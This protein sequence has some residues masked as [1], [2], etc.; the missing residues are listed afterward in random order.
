LGDCPQNSHSGVGGRCLSPC[1]LLQYNTTLMRAPAWWAI[2]PAFLGPGWLAGCV[3][4]WAAARCSFGDGARCPP[5][6]APCSHHST[7]QR[8]PPPCVKGARG[9]R[10]C[11]LRCIL[12]SPCIVA[13]QG[14][15]ALVCPTLLLVDCVLPA[16]GMSLVR[17][18]ARLCCS[19]W[20]AWLCAHGHGTQAWRSAQP[21]FHRGVVW[22]PCM[23]R[24]CD[25]L[26]RAVVL[27]TEMR[28]EERVVWLLGWS[29]LLPCQRARSTGL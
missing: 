15:P 4:G 21:V 1:C 26:C 2:L 27:K 13:P 10:A 6:P 8:P 24:P 28:A 19:S 25:C 23:Y 22:C 3:A 12:S 17:R 16:R 29:W 20:S 14:L 11:R 9:C 18:P 7:A 5:C